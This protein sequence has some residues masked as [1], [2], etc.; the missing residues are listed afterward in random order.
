MNFSGTLGAGRPGERVPPGARRSRRAGAAAHVR[1]QHA[2]A[3]QQRPGAAAARGQRAPGA[4]GAR[5]RHTPPHAAGQTP[6]C[7]RY[8]M[9]INGLKT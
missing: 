4:G 5:V 3:A 8:D 2:A 9:S 7:A 6:W 1:G